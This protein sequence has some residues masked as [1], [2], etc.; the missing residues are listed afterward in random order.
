[1]DTKVVGPANVIFDQKL[2]DEVLGKANPPPQKIE[3]KRKRADEEINE[4]IDE[5]VIERF[6]KITDISS[7]LRQVEC[8]AQLKY[9]VK[10]ARAKLSPFGKRCIEVQNHQGTLPI[11]ALAK[12]V[13]ELV[14]KNPDF[15]EVERSHGKAC[16]KPI[17]DI[18]KEI[19]L[20]VEK[21]KG[22]KRTLTKLRSI[23]YLILSCFSRNYSKIQ[24][25]WRYC[26][27]ATFDSSLPDAKG[28]YQLFKL[29]TKNQYK[30]V[31][32]KD[33]TGN[34]IKLHG[35]NNL[36]FLKPIEMNGLLIDR[37]FILNSPFS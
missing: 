20:Q 22:L 3:F 16:I 26:K 1:M 7:A 24:W 12:K 17:N 32:Q 25:N 13:L 31:F 4:R 35:I 23:P 19:D 14:K 15:D 9:I 8:F 11:D 30:A 34:P 29:Y 27:I 36:Y 37:S 5:A 6:Q 10:N 18:Y 28:N 21:A 33:P 2:L